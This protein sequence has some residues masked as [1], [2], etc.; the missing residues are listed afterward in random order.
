MLILAE[1]V[2]A[3]ALTYTFGTMVGDTRQ[4]WAILAAMLSVLA[5]FVL[6]AYWAE[7]AGNPRL[8]MLGVEQTAGS[9]QSGGNMEGRKFVSGSPVRRSLPP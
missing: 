4:G 6:V 1:T 2:I 3:A 7:S 5:L 8:A 9:A